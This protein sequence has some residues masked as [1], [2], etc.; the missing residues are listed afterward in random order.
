MQIQGKW[1]RALGSIALSGVLTAALG[2]GALLTG[3][4]TPSAP[5]PPS[6]K[7]PERV[8]DLTASRAG[9]AVTLQ[10]TTPR[11]TT[12]RLLIHGP[13]RAV[14]CRRESPGSGCTQAGE[15]TVAP[16]AAGEFHDKL[17]AALTSGKSRELH[18]FVELKNSKGR[19]AGLSNAAIVLA[20][21]APGP[22]AG[23]SAEVRA[24]GV[25]LRWNPEPGV[26]TEVRLHR[27]LLT[28]PASKQQKGG[29]LQ[30][31]TEPLLRDL[32]VGLPAAGQ[33]TGALDATAHFGESYEYTAQRVDRVGADNPGGKQ[34]LELAGPVSAP[35]K[36]DVVDV[37]PPAVPQD[38]A[39]VFVPEKNTIDLSWQPD[40]ESDLAGYIVYRAVDDGEWKRISGPEPLS[41]PA[42]RD[43][44]IEN[45]HNYRYAVSAIDGS[46]HESKRSQEATESTPKP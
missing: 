27:K 28:P 22:V 33:Q 41:G 1:S 42:Y 45:G 17:P 34:I 2:C 7:L 36:V 40:T 13:V 18:Y 3:C 38:L 26:E 25:A 44:A 31:E 5:Q 29:A 30:P 6:L 32:L 12:D 4:G 15:V 19:S 20:G 21:A 9:D 37:F 14:I 11:K 10:W 39:A 23:L 8:S 16:R 43:A 24:D 35:V 46:G